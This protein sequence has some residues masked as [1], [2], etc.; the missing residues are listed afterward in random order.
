M[1]KLIGI[2]IVYFFIFFNI[3][4]FSCDK[5]EIPLKIAFNTWIG[6]GPFYVAKE[7]G[8]FKNANLR[9][10]L[11]RMEGT[12]ERRAALIAKR[13]DAL[14]STIDD[15]VVGSSQGLNGVMV[16]AIDES[17]GADGI[18][19]KKGINS[20]RDFK[21]K[22]IAVQPGFVNHFFLLYLLQKYSL[23]QDDIIIYPM[24][25]DKAANALLSGDVDVA[26][27]WEP[28]LSV[29][30]NKK[31]FNLI[32]TTA[33]SIAQHI[34]VDNLIIR[35]DVLK[36]R[37]R[38]VERLLR[39]WFHTLDFIQKNPDESANIMAKSVGITAD[40][41]KEMLKGLKFV[42]LEDNLKFFN[43]THEPNFFSLARKALLL[44]T[45]AKVIENPSRAQP[46]FD[47][48]NGEI[49]S[50]IINHD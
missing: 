8:F 34:I 24:E 47:R 6:Y 14:G 12:G 30:K 15:F 22:K 17:F 48:I 32:L 29:I 13:I 49:I 21:N 41:A 37:E 16:L 5:N 50:K 43:K 46:L 26:V 3:F 33:D 23:S 31:G 44:Y 9:V 4:F 40:E 2:L 10:E 7:K 42:S 27:T 25:P 45:D 38:D 18:V 39:V 28:H 11:V 20:V 35:D 19:A 1:R 36:E